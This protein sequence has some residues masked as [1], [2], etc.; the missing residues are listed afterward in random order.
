[1]FLSDCPFQIPM[2]LKDA[3][4]VDDVRGS[5]LV[6]GALLVFDISG[7]GEWGRSDVAMPGCDVTV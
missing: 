2:T 1:M 4:A 5:V 7:G 3:V 6:K